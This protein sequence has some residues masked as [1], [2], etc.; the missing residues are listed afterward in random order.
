MFSARQYSFLLVRIVSAD[1]GIVVIR[2]L[3]YTQDRICCIGGITAIPT[4]FCARRAQVESESSH[5]NLPTPDKK[6]APNG[7]FFRH[8][9][10]VA[11]KCISGGLQLP[12]GA[13]IMFTQWHNEKLA[14][15][16]TGAAQLINLAQPGDCRP[17]V[18]CD[19]A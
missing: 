15:K 9:A 13:L 6:K 10:D 11:H 3:V 5:Q 7:T 2:S 8:T 1:D 14:C 19:G 4:F 17:A 18:L 12:A 16:N